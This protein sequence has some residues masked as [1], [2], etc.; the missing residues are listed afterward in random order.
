LTPDHI[1]KKDGGNQNLE[2]NLIG[3]ATEC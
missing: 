2:H 1:F 3:K